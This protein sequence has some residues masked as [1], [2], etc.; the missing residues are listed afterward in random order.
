LETALRVWFTSRN[1]LLALLLS[2]ALGALVFYAVGTGYFA[3]AREPPAS[4]AVAARSLVSALGRIEPASETIN[5]GPGVAPDR[6]D[7]LFV[8]RGEV[9]QQ[10]QV[11]GYL[12]GY[13][14]Q[15][16]QLD[17]YRSQLEEARLRLKTEIELNQSRIEAAETRQKQILE[18]SP[19]RIAAQEATIVSLQAKLAN[20]RDILAS[21]S[22]LYSRGIS[23]RRLQ[24]DQQA[25]VLQGEA[26][27]ASA[28]ARLAEL[29]QQFT[30]D[31]IDAEVQIKV[32]RYQLERSKA[33]FP[34][35][36]LQ[37]QVALAEARRQRL[38]ITAPI[39][40]R[41]LNIKVKP[42]EVVGNGPILTMGDTSRMHAVA[43]VYETDIG[44]VKVGQTAT[45]T[46]RALPRQLT[47]KVVRIGNMIF[48]NDVLNVDPA[49]RADARVVEV[50]IDLDEPAMI[51]RLTNLTVDV[52]INTD[53][54]PPAV[55]RSGKP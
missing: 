55:A 50:W 18:V 8:A 23:S 35:A 5:I 49:A 14:E 42:G 17:M 38:T 9:V 47:G 45:I 39:A 7:T 46:S 31:Q 2:L 40:G 29:K 16:A 10:G 33:E 24:E 13:S 26:N 28:R 41:I 15:V 1:L 11:L 48:K 27:I 30:F 37:S 12:G 36:S 34:V 19:L 44:R 3:A 43:E 32:A 6:L 20:D 53:S 4:V 21:Q 25:M 52:V 51:E 22:Q 54:V